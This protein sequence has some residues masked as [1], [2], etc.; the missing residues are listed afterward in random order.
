M[1][2]E[3]LDRSDVLLIG[4]E[5]RSLCVAPVV[6][7]LARQPVLLEHGVESRKDVIA[8]QRFPSAGAAQCDYR[9]PSSAG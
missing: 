2:H 4:E 5:A 8:P 6:D 3:L 7:A 9:E 1:A